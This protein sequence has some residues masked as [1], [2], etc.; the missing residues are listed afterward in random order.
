MADHLL[1]HW[2]RHI[3]MHAGADAAVHD[4]QQHTALAQFRNH[5][6]GGDARAVGPEEHQI[7]LGLLHLDAV[8]LREPARQRPRIGMVVRET[9]DVM[10]ERVNTACSANAGLPHRAA[11]PLLPAPD[12]VNEG[13]GSCDRASD[14]RTQPL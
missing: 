2:R 3:E 10:V 14:R 8:D 1:D 4:S 5:P 6:V 11:E 7:G 13:A 12:L 9:V